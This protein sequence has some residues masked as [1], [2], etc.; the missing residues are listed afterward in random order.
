MDVAPGS[1]GKIVDFEGK[2][3]EIVV[4]ARVHAIWTSMIKSLSFW[5][6]RGGSGE[7]PGGSGEAP[8]WLWEAP[9]SS[10]RAQEAPGRLQEAPGRL[11]EAPGALLEAPGEARGG[12]DEFRSAN[13]C[14][15]LAAGE[16]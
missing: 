11:Q 13:N 14:A 4:F 10:G 6:L 8:G 7:A 5:R 12:C 15:A 2:I 9:G 16:G 3:V 1:Q